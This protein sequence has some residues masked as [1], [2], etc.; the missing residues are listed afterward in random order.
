MAKKLNIYNL[1]EIGVDVSASPLHRKPGT[2]TKAQN[3]VMLPNEGEGAIEKRAGMSALNA[4]LAG[5]IWGATNVSVN[6]V[7]VTRLWV[8]YED[9]VVAGANWAY[10]EDGTTWVNS[11]APAAC[12]QAQRRN[13]AY[14]HSFQPVQGAAIG[15]SMLYPADDYGIYEP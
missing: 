10:T 5:Q 9:T 12:F 11:N 14:H 1:A 3:A 8:A 13:A 7:A 6:P 2:L 15:A 4:A